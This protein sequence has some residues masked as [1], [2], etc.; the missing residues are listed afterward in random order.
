IG[1]GLG[2]AGRQGRLA[3]PA[4]L[5]VVA[6]LAAAEPAVV[7]PWLL[8]GTLLA[9]VALI[10]AASIAADDGGPHF[11][12]AAFVIAAEVLWSDRHLT[13]ARIYDALT[14]YAVFGVFYAAVPLVAE[15]LH[16]RLAPGIATAV[17][18]V[19]SIALVFFL[20][21]GPVAHVAL[22]AVGALLALFLTLL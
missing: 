22:V 13:E 2:L 18:L 16:R 8:F 7:S 9:L 6:F 21:A 11:L 14:L 19:A 5:A 10:A 17:T 4:L 1:Y 15:R 12:G 3:A 20:A